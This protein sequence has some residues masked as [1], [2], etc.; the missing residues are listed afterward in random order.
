VACEAFAR[1][2][3]PRRRGISK[4]VAADGLDCRT[5]A[6]TPITSRRRAYVEAE[7][8]TVE[9]LGIAEL[10][11]LFIYSSGLPSGSGSLASVRQ[12]RER[13][14]NTPGFAIY[15]A[16]TKTPGGWQRTPGRRAHHQKFNVTALIPLLR[17][18][19]ENSDNSELRR[20]SC[21]LSHSGH[22]AVLHRSCSE[23][24]RV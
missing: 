3:R 6:L 9:G 14:R 1:G 19:V 10:A 20:I 15:A 18:P 4:S 2:S 24:L 12:I 23:T 5:T 13:P 21:F 8:V 22:R 11:G 16:F 7:A 17:E